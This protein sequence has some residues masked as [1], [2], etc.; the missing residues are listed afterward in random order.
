MQMIAIICLFLVSPNRRVRF[1]TVGEGAWPPPR[2]SKSASGSKVVPYSITSVEHGADPGFLAVSP[3]VTLGWYSCCRYFPS[4]IGPLLL[5][6]SKR[7]SPWPVPNYT[8]WWQWHTGVSST[9]C[10]AR[11]RTRDLASP[12]KYE[13]SEYCS[14]IGSRTR[15]SSFDR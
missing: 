11:T 15:F 10:P 7:S 8:A 6:Q 9:W 2:P 4:A 13:R 14:L 3:Q 5:S 12:A 1:C